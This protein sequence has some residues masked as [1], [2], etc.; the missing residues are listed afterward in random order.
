MKNKL[1]V[2]S[3]IGSASLTFLIIIAVYKIYGYAPFGNM[4]LAAMDANIQYLD[5]FAY[6]KDVLTGENSLLYTFGKTLGGSNIAVF[7]YYLSSPFSLLVIFFNKE[8]L[9]TFFDLIIALKLS[10]AAA[11]FYVYMNIR[12]TLADEKTCLSKCIHLIMPVSY[13]LSQYSIA[14][15]SN[16]MW[17]DGVYMLPLILAF[18]YKLLHDSK[19]NWQ[20]SICVALSILFNWYTAGI[21][22]LYSGIY[23]LIELGLIW[24]EH[25][26]QT[27]IWNIK[28]CFI[29]LWKYLY[30]MAIGVLI[31]GIIFL[32][33]I[34][35]LK[36]SS[37]GTLEFSRLLNISFTGEIPSAITK[38][39]L[40]ALSENGSV[41]L[42]CG[43]VTLIGCMG[44]FLS[45]GISKKRK[46]IL[47]CFLGITI[48]S[49]YWNPLWIIFSLFKDAS[50]YWYR[51]S[52]IGIFTFLF[53]ASMLFIQ[54]DIR[55]DIAALCKAVVCFAFFQLVLNYVRPTVD[56][57]LLYRTVC[58]LC[59]ILCIIIILS[60][61]PFRRKAIHI[62]LNAA[63]ILC[64]V[65]ELFYNTHLLTRNY[66]VTDVPQYRAYIEGEEK[67]IGAIKEYDA[68]EPYRITQTVTRNMQENALTAN[69]N[70][71]LAYNY[72]SISGY[73]SSP[74]DIQRNFLDR[75]GYRINGDNMCIVNTSILGADA[76]LGVKYV[77]SQYQIN[78]LEKIG[79]LKS[80]NN[81]EVYR[82]PYS[83]PF[84][85][86]Y[87][88]TN[89]D[90]TPFDMNGNPFEY[91]NYLY[92]QLLGEKINLYIP[93]HYNMS[94]N[95]SQQTV[96]Y[97]LKIPDGNYA[98]Y[99]NLPWNWEV[100]AV[101]DINHQLQTAYSQWLSPS[102]FYV[103]TQSGDVSASVSVTAG[104][105]NGF[106]YGR[107]QFC[108][109]DLSEL[110]RVT[111]ILSMQT[112]DIIEIQNGYVHIKT[113]SD[114]EDR[115]YISIPYD[116]G[117]KISLNGHIVKPELF[118]DCMYS[119]PL[120][121][122]SNEI[123]MTYSPPGLNAGIG[124][125]F[126]GLGLLIS[127][128]LIESKVYS[129]KQRK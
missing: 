99:G 49:F 113:C 61:Y 78:G 128:Y 43:S 114:G 108:A 86:R 110:E 18:I 32:P 59:M 123:E 7:S 53:I 51:Y 119:I 77:R 87:G 64:V 34:A 66:F 83:L 23:F 89:F 96:G 8:N 65:F 1:I 93:L 17:L 56:V 71:S 63:L 124:S 82:N 5:F 9:H 80:V 19:H 21:N 120:E 118:A 115:I 62:L 57:Q 31:S 127:C 20:L 40:G 94:R 22:C 60:C 2:F 75:L 109:L 33:T 15:S 117:W 10:L 47:G 68:Q 52:Y 126:L 121:I 98:V 36:N 35:A 37:R 69:Y 101:L 70:E 76:L 46:L 28:Y 6:F 74:D 91:Q 85:F 81:K 116:K 48:L 102:V 95:D 42:Y 72:W 45:K 112:S 73:T 26:N 88:S 30:S 107:E 14:Q 106:S 105:L 67:Q 4:S 129:R 103:P 29:K 13:A 58:L 24:A 100:N 3:S 122:G 84:A 97:Q 25:R 16:V 79:N 125:T 50:S 90:T 41:S 12:F 44:A 55:Q 111:E 39:S 54:K 104:D 92:S 38:Y 27:R 11:T